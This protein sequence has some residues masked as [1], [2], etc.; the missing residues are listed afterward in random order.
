MNKSVEGGGIT[1]T[2]SERK[3]EDNP[4]LHIIAEIKEKGKRA[5]K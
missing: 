2:T 1:L 4:N 5:R 3:K